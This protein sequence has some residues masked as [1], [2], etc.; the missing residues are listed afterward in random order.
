MKE[1]NNE[2]ETRASPDHHGRAGHGFRCRVGAEALIPTM[3]PVLAAG[4]VDLVHHPVQD[5][6][7]ETQE[8]RSRF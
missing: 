6:E 5:F 1:R 3:N 7:N 2:H 8:M 4:V